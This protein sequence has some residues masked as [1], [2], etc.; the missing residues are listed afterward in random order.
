MMIITPNLIV[1]LLIPLGYSKPISMTEI[2]DTPRDKLVNLVVLQPP[3]QALFQ[4]KVILFIAHTVHLASAICFSG[5]YSIVVIFSVILRHR[6]PKC[7][8]IASFGG[9]WW[10]LGVYI[11]SDIIVAFG[12]TFIAVTHIWECCH[13]CFKMVSEFHHNKDD[14]C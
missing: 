14:S 4:K 1:C 5:L 12:L 7:P 13:H 2:D 6:C 10:F 11:E 8:L 3:G 9:C